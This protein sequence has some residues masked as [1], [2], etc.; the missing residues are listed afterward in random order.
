MQVK[1]K[2][3]VDGESVEDPWGNDL[4]TGL[5]AESAFD[6]YLRVLDANG[7]IPGMLCLQTE[8]HRFM[9]GDVARINGCQLE[10]A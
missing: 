7:C 8:Y 5:S 10:R 3:T 9:A 1:F 4:R 2:I 6:A